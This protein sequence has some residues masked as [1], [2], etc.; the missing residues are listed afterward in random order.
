METR[1]LLQHASTI[2]CLPVEIAK[3]K[4]QRVYRS[5]SDLD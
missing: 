1:A 4:Y 3:K 5:F 2:R